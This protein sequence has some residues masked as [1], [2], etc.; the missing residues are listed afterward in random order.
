[1]SR[2]LAK[3][4]DRGEPDGTW[5]ALGAMR[6]PLEIYRF[7]P[8]TIRQCYPA[9]AP[10]VWRQSTFVVASTPHDQST[11]AAGVA[12]DLALLATVV[13]RALA[14]APCEVL[15]FGSQA[16]GDARPRSDI[17]IAL[18]ATQALPRDTLV[19]LRAA[20]EDSNVVRRVDIVDW[21]AASHAMRASIEREAVPWLK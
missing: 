1:M 2:S 13:R 3:G 12:L 10:H 7:L 11:P 17:D 4:R 8:T 16:R 21:W 18:R 5:D 20:V 19:A 6:R 14:D 15:L 9:R